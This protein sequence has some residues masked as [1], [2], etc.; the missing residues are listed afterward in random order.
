MSTVP[1]PCTNAEPKTPIDPCDRVKFILEADEGEA[2]GG[3]G[4]KGS[5][6]LFTELEELRCDHHNRLEEGEGVRSACEHVH[7]TCT[8]TLQ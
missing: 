1:P 7:C 4:N 3:E 6:S 2:D 5:H 8:S